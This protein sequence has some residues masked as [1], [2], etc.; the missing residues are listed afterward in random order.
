MTSSG[1]L[2]SATVTDFSA[3][4]AAL[5]RSLGPSKMLRTVEHDSRWLNSELIA[6]SDD[7]WLI[8]NFEHS[9]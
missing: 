2:F 9:D 8:L 1:N 3:R 5:Y 7:D 6:K 4:D